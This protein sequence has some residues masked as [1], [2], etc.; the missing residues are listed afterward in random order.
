METYLCVGILGRQEDDAAADTE[1]LLD[2]SGRTDG[3]EDWRLRVAQDVDGQHGTS[4]S[5]RGAEVRGL[6]RHLNGQRKVPVS[7]IQRTNTP[8]IL[9]KIVK[10]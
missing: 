2:G 7:V 10:K 4:A 1:S 8:Y 3:E 5:G 9:S 6:Y